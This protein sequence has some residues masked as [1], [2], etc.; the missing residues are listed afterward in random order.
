MYCTYVYM[1]T[2]LNRI[3]VGKSCRKTTISIWKLT[4]QSS[5]KSWTI[6]GKIYYRCCDV[7]IHVCFVQVTTCVAPDALT[8]LRCTHFHSVITPSWI[9][10]QIS[11]EK[12]AH[13]GV[14]ACGECQTMV[15]IFTW[16]KQT[17]TK[18]HNTIIFEE[19]IWWLIFEPHKGTV[20]P[21]IRSILPYIIQLFSLY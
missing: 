10:Q 11:I 13:Q 16:T 12:C 7:F 17:W 18:H 14:S 19:K 20:S 21:Y 5:S 15:K 1:K 4:R 6:S 8:R 3:Q 9:T 2:G